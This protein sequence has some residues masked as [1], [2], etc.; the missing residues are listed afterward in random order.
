LAVRGP[1]AA[2]VLDTAVVTPA[3]AGG[4]TVDLLEMVLAGLS[5]YRPDCCKNIL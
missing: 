1:P 4:A 5:G 3:L 2:A